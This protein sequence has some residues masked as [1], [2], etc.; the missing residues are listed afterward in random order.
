[1]WEVF[2]EL[3]CKKDNVENMC[4]NLMSHHCIMYAEPLMEGGK[5]EDNIHTSVIQNEFSAYIMC[6]AYVL[7]ITDERA[8]YRYLHKLDGIS[9]EKFLSQGK[10]KALLDHIVKTAG[11]G[12]TIIFLVILSHEIL[13]SLARHEPLELVEIISIAGIAAIVSFIIESVIVWNEHNK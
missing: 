9:V 13:I 1:M 10:N 5:D 8:L 6:T 12:A 7:H 11:I 4:R 2:I 3:K